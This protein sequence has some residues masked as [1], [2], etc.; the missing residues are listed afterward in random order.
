MRAFIILALVCALPLVASGPVAGQVVEVHGDTTTVATD[1]PANSSA[2]PL[3]VYSCNVDQCLACSNS[4]PNFC[5]LC[6]KGYRLKGKTCERRCDV[7]G[8]SACLPQTS[9]ICGL[10]RD[11]LPPLHNV[12][13]HTADAVV[14]SPDGR[15]VLLTGIA[16]ALLSSVFL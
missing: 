16:A 3:G 15:D 14:A 8:C 12:C 6:T 13:Y 4:D 1:K 10:C 5:V 11:G 2:I 7:R 9:R